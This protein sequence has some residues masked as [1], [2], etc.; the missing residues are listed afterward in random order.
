MTTY[1]DGNGYY[2]QHLEKP[3]GSTSTEPQQDSSDTYNS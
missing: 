2:G 3:A 1:Q